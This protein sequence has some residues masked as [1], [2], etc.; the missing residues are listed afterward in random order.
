MERP[1]CATC[2]Y[3]R[4]VPSGSGEGDCHRLP[5]AVLLVDDTFISRWPPVSDYQGCGEHP[6]F[7]AYVRSL[8]TISRPKPPRN[9]PKVLT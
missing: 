7:P 5:P 1:T 4:E 6:A 3:F 8:G 9:H 2:P